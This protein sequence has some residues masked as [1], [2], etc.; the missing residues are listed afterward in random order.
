LKF[1]FDVTFDNL[2]RNELALLVYSLTPTPEFR[3]RLGM[4][5]PLGLGTVD[6]E[7]LAVF[8]VDRRRR[9]AE[10]NVFGAGRYH[11]ASRCEDTPSSLDLTHA[12]LDVQRR[13]AE[14]QAAWAMSQ[15]GPACR[16]LRA[17]A[18]ALLDKYA[19]QARAAVE[20][21]GDPATTQ[22]VPVHY[23]RLPDALQTDKTGTVRREA[24]LYQWHVWNE[25]R[26]QPQGLQ[27]LTKDNPAPG[28]L[29]KQAPFRFFLYSHLPDDALRELRKDLQK[30]YPHACYPASGQLASSTQ[31]Y[32][33]EIKKTI[34]QGM[35]P[36]HLGVHGQEKINQ[37]Y[38]NPN[39]GAI[40]A[41]KDGRPV[42]VV[43]EFR[44][45]YLPVQT[46]TE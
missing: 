45:K 40:F 25:H 41:T 11:S 21:M 30:N 15:P 33:D 37:A 17:S 5:K 39:Y 22:G 20:K 42:D 23:P 1:V 18:V 32:D 29:S 31:H 44:R 46:S 2:T 27:P 24:R 43:R 6:V 12:A 14:E 10:D 34:E 3:H 35:I 4:G 28:R 36:V 26:P 16:E 13:Y 9:Y 8:F 19:A 7:P 38:L